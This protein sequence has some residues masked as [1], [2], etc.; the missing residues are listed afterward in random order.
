M[1]FFSKVWK[2]VKKGFKKIGKAIKKGFKSF[3]KFMGKIGILGTI[4][5]TMLTGGLGIGAAFTNFGA[6][7]AGSSSALLRGAGWVIGKAAQFGTAVKSGF[8]TLTKGVTEFFGQ[9]AKYVA[10]KIPGVNIQGAPTSFLGEGGVWQNT[11]EA[12]VKQFETFRGDAINL[13]NTT[14]PTLEAGKLAASISKEVGTLGEYNA[15]TGGFEYNGQT[16]EANALVPDPSA[17]TLGSDIPGTAVE[18]ITS[19]VDQGPVSLSDG[20]VTVGT[21]GLE[22]ISS[23]IASTQTPSLLSRAYDSA[24]DNLFEGVTKAPGA[25]VT[26]ALV[27]KAM[28]VGEV[29]PYYNTTPVAQFDSSYALAGAVEQGLTQDPDPLWSQQ[30]FDYD[31]YGGG[32]GGYSN[33][34][35]NRMQGAMS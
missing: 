19:K 4:A 31:A 18:G 11:S 23:E 2:G 24:K 21:G 32:Q 6:T 16:L 28:G 30:L 10:N 9:T 15:S 27:N 33:V 7:L 8:Q 25:V 29:D 12:V 17:P 26:T 14:S 3:G 35:A 1:G 13:F 22:D 5:L 34:Y 20:T